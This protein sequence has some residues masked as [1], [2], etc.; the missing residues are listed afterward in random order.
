MQNYVRMFFLMLLDALLVNVAVVMSIILIAHTNLLYEQEYGKFAAAMTTISLCSFY[1]LGLYNRIWEYASTGEIYAVIKS[2]TLAALLQFGLNHFYFE[3]YLPNTGFF[4][5]WLMTLFL[6]AGS[7]YGWR[8]TRDFYHVWQPKQ[9]KKPVLI[10]GAGAA[11]AMVA[12]A[13]MDNNTDLRP[14]GFIDDSDFKQNM[15]LLGL[16]VVG[17]RED[18]PAVVDR[19]G[20]EEIIIAIPSASSKTIRELVNISRNTPVRLKITPSVFDYIEGK[21]NLGKIRDVE[22][23]DLLHREPVKVNLQKIAGYLKGRAVLVT[24]A[25]GSVGSELCRQVAAFK[26]RLIILLGRGENSVYEAELSLQSLYPDVQRVIEIADVRDQNR[27]ECIFCRYRPE[28]I[29]HAAA[30]KHVPLM[31]KSPEEAFSNNVLGTLN[32]ARAAKQ[33]QAH[34][35]V[36]ISTDKAVNPKSVMGATKRVAEM[37]MQRLSEQSRTKFVS[38]RFGNVL[39]SRGSVVPLFK[40]QIAAGGPVTVTDPGMVRYFMTIP[41]AVQLVIQAGAMV[42]G[43][44]IFLLDMGEPVRIVDLAR[45]LIKL[46]GFRPDIDI[47]IVFTGVRPGEKLFEDLYTSGERIR[48]T[49]HERIMVVESENCFPAILDKMI[50]QTC[51]GRWPLDEKKSLD[52]LQRLIP[53]FAAPVERGKHD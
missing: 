51:P 30:H 46:S 24:G 2:V 4:L 50:F 52:L 20:V 17:K 49:R 15:K 42:Q 9:L 23:E 1:F 25:G 33:Y 40:K 29:F 26:P 45:D 12:R 38:V 3:D 32:V 41:E 11:G 6:L 43:G 7:R 16:P 13:I 19:Y 8:L 21:V 18:I 31:E 53:D 34:V 35:F 39:G 44:E 47:P 5:I 37:I 28:V 10:V 22:V 36:L 27:V 14:V 48:K